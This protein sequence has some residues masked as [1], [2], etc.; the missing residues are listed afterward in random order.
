MFNVI[1][2]YLS[3]GITKILIDNLGGSSGL[4]RQV[5]YVLMDIIGSVFAWFIYCLIIAFPFVFY[6][7]VFTESFSLPA[8]I[9]FTYANYSEMVLWLFTLNDSS[10]FGD[11][12]S[13]NLPY[14][15]IFIYTSIFSSLWI[16]LHILGGALVRLMII[17]QRRIS[18]NL[19]ILNVD[20]KPFQSIGA[21]AV[22]S[23]NVLFFLVYAVI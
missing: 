11:G 1:P 13:I 17:A 16:V 22:I 8:S 14:I 4:L 3:L 23:F 21:F 15:Q 20:E 2:D 9:P 10:Y 12:D 5:I 19:W 6:E 7:L 18:D